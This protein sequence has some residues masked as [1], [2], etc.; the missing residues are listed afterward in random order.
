MQKSA[1]SRA[2]T[3]SS[4][5]MEDGQ[6]LQFTEKRCE[7]RRTKRCDGYIHLPA[8]GWYCRRLKT[9]RE[10]DIYARNLF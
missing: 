3:D 8:V 7:N 2:N 1:I 10:T 5:K 4:V 9:R 6:N